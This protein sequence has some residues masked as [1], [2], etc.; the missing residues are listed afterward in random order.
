MQMARTTAQARPSPRTLFDLVATDEREALA[1]ALVLGA[2]LEVVDDEKNRPL[3]IAVFANKLEN[4]DVLL[5]WSACPP[6]LG[7]HRNARAPC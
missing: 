6:L 3:H 1:E 5:N 7:A 2:N 4:V